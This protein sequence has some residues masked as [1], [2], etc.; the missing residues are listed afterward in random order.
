[1]LCHCTHVFMY[2]MCIL[3]WDAQLLLF[4][5]CKVYIVMNAN[6]YMKSFVTNQVYLW[7]SSEWDCQVAMLESVIN[8]MEN[9]FQLNKRINYL[10][11]FLMTVSSACAST[12]RAV[13]TGDQNSIHPPHLCTVKTDIRIHSVGSVVCLQA[14]TH[15]QAS[16][17]P[18]RFPFSLSGESESAHGS[19][20]LNPFLIDL[21]LIL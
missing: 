19:Q 20:S 4:M 18:V 14:Q 12:I 16:H 17:F 2:W 11:A 15:R 1:M 7:C 10:H 8:N 21:S 9:V 6:P 5:Y 3:I 13:W